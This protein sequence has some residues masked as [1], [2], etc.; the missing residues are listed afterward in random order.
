MIPSNQGLD[1][2]PQQINSYHLST[3]PIFECHLGNL[4]FITPLPTPVLTIHWEYVKQV[5]P[6]SENQFPHLK[7][8]LLFNPNQS[9]R[10]KKT[11][12]KLRQGG[13]LPLQAPSQEEF[14]AFP[15][16]GSPA[17]TALGARREPFPGSAQ[18]RLPGD[19]EAEL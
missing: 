10:R 16:K 18:G 4:G 9:G 2:L 17:G 5:G 8:D 13:A 14:G 15:I 6:N 19:P 1:L 7:T 12:I 3:W 11:P